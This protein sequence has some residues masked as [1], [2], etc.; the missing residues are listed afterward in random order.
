MLV[1]VSSGDL[2]GDFT[3]VTRVAMACGCHVRV[4]P[5]PMAMTDPYVCH[6]N[7]LPFTINIPQSC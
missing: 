2:S 4:P 6:M 5:T 1:P 3:D 7:G